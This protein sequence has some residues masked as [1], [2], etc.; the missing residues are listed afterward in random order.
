[1]RKHLWFAMLLLLCGSL[2]VSGCR[3]AQPD[4]LPPITDTASSRGP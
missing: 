4:S 3:C 2:A 1:M